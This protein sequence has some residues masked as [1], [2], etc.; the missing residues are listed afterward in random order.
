[1]TKTDDLWDELKGPPKPPPM[2][3]KKR[4]KTEYGVQ[5]E[6]LGWLT[7]IGAVS[8]VTDAGMLHRAGINAACDIPP[9]WPDITVCLP[10][11]RFLGL[12]CKS[13]KGRQSEYQ[14]F[15]Q[16]RIEDAG[17]LYVLA[18]SLEE[19]QK[20]ILLVLHSSGS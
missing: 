13:A 18:H 10:G 5:R 16:C 1:M 6:I 8:V 19:A 12:E 7:S 14:K 11:G 3:R 20:K 2:R 17:G 9:G 4:K 15:V